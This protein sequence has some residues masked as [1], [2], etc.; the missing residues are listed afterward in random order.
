VPEVAV[1]VSTFEKPSHL[2]RVLVSLAMQE[3][4]RG[5]MEVVVTDD[6]SRDETRSIVTEFARDAPFPVHFATHPHDG[7]QLAR[8]RNDGVRASRAGYLLFLDGDC[9]VPRDHVRAHLDHRRRGWV[10]GGYCC[11]LDRDVSDRITEAAIREDA[12]A[13]WVPRRELRRVAQRHR[14]AVLYSFLRHRGKPKLAGGNIGVWRADYERVNGYDENFVGWGG[15]DD[16]LRRRLAGV[17][18]RVGSILRWT[19]TYHLWHPPTP[20][21]A[22]SYWQGVNVGYLH[23]PGRLTRCRHGLVE[24]PLSDISMRIVGTPADPHAA[25]AFLD[26]HVPHRREGD[27]AEVE[28]LFTPGAGRFTGRAQC[29]VLISL[30]SNAAAVR[31]ATSRRWQASHRR[32]H[33]VLCDAS[34]EQASGGASIFFPSRDAAA[35]FDAIK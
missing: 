19:H 17:G 11:R 22:P 20:T 5:A 12:Y 7:F 31:R 32:P 34:P 35:L 29:N 16:D 3:G 1:L 23:R 33:L 8:C 15:E 28:I 6:G 2:R 27:P 25:R 30:D 4:V 26:R 14:K 18:L 9:V 13:T 21:A 24:R 10:M